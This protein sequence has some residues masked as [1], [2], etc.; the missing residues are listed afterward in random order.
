VAIEY[1]WAEGHY[2]Q[3]PAL[4]DDLVQRKVAVI[5]AGGTGAALAAKAATTTLPIV[6]AVGADPVKLGL[7]AELGRLGGNVTGVSFLGSGLIDHSQKM[8]VAAIRIA[9]KNVRAHR[10]YRV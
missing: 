10:S 7:V 3:L 6:M 2:D 4:A 1:R 8:T 5:A 9:D